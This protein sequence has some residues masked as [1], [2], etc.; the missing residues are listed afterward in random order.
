MRQATPF[1]RLLVVASLMLFVVGLSPTL[2]IGADPMD[3]MDPM[4]PIDPMGTMGPGD[5]TSQLSIVVFDIG[6]SF[7]ENAPPLGSTIFST[8]PPGSNQL[9]SSVQVLGSFSLLSDRL[10]F[11]M[12]IPGLSKQAVLDGALSG[13]RFSNAPVGMSGPVVHFV[14]NVGVGNGGSVIGDWNIANPP[15]NANIANSGPLTGDL[16]SELFASRIYVTIGIN[17]DFP[18]PGDPGRELRGQLIP[19]FTPEPSSL[20]MYSASAFVFGVAAW[21]RRK[22][23][24]HRRS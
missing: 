3:P 1:S 23:A 4:D 5:Q 11:S 7:P 14:N 6:D 10:A 17:P 2:A 20:A 16:I 18:A 15:L 21:R 8:I 22:S 9:S 19:I 13:I 24:A 12:S